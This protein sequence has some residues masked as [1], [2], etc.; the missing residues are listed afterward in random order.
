MR[1]VARNRDNSLGIHIDKPTR[2][3]DKGIWYSG[4]LMSFEVPEELLSDYDN[5]TW[6]DE[7]VPINITFANEI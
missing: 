7:P 1:H 6:D 5:L 3:E 4:I 2:D